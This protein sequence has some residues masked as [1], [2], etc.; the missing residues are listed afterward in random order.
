MVPDGDPRR[1]GDL[2]RASGAEAQLERVPFFVDVVSFEC[3]V[4]AGFDPVR[5]T[6]PRVSMEAFNQRA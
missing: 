2:G 1:L 5:R 6:F 4:E 3:G